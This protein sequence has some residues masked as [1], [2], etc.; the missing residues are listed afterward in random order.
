MKENNLSFP[1]S[2]ERFVGQLWR[3]HP[4]PHLIVGG[5]RLVFNCVSEFS[6]CD[7]S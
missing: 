2:G 6:R 5:A 7:L 1:V 3:L 4:S